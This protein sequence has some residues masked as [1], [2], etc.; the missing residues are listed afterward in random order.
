M[1]RIPHTFQTP[2]RHGAP[3]PRSISP[4]S[5]TNRRTFRAHLPT[6]THRFL[7]RPPPYA[8]GST[9]WKRTAHVSGGIA[10]TSLPRRSK[11]AGATILDH[12]RRDRA[13]TAF[14]V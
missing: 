12:A 4:P 14:L 2:F 8:T 5:K 9:V 6:T 1:W 7:Q 3:G 11:K 13:G 10:P